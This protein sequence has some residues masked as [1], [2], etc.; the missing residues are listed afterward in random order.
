MAGSLLEWSVTGDAVIMHRL[1]AR[2]L[3]ERHQTRGQWA[4]TVAAALNLIKPL[5]FPKVQAWPRRADG[6]RLSAQIEAL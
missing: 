5:L 2:V 3:R 1:L 6:A 4:R